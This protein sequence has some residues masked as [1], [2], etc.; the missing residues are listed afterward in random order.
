MKIFISYAHLNLPQ[1]QQL[2]DFLRM[3]G[4]DIWYDQRLVGGQP[5][6]DQLRSQI[7][8]SQCFLYALTPESVASAWCQW[9]FAQAVHMGK[10][11]VTVKLTE[12]ELKGI[13]AEHQYIDFTQGDSLETG[14][15]LGTAV[16]A[17][18]PIPPELVPLLPEPDNTP[19]EREITH[20]TPEQDTL[21]Q[22][23]YDEAFQVYRSKAY[24]EAQE[25]LHDLLHIAPDF[26]DAQNLLTL[27]ERKL[28]TPAIEKPH[29]KE[30]PSPRREPEVVKP[31]PKPAVLAASSILPPPFEWVEI[32]VGK[33]TLE[34][35]GYLSELTIFDIEQ[36]AIAKYPVT[37]A[38][39]AVFME[40]GGYDNRDYWTGEG[41]ATR[42]EKGWIEPRHWRDEHFNPEDHPVVGVS[43]YEVMA[44]C[45]WL[46]EATGQAIILPTEQQWQRAAQGDDGREYPWGREPP[47]EQLCNWH[48]NIGRTTPVKQYPKGASYYGVM[49]MGGN[50]WEWCLTEYETGTSEPGGTGARVLRG[51]SWFFDS[52]ELLRAAY[53]NWF[54]PASW[55]FDFGFRCARLP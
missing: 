46:S 29:P 36:F 14:L 53:R 1:V 31:A 32:P 3:G 16:Y 2:A 49:D 35:G 18:L 25:L 24:A 13:L 10:T 19:P 48:N 7:K 26:A 21:V 52:P 34:E 38:Q 41:W 51:G 54:Y 39:F 40:A 27:V 15:R 8:T 30:K 23:L 55:N 22:R 4:H 50:V 5:W 28:P 12:C 20:D 43:W 6:K 44:F 47:N 45:Q 11:I 17:A 42:E 9:E 33:V 37:N